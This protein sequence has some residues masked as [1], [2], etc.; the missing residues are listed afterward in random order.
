[1]GFISSQGFGGNQ[2]VFKGAIVK[3][4]EENIQTLNLNTMLLTTETENAITNHPAITHA[5][6]IPDS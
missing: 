6:D 4:W 1:M 5:R 2:A 3:F